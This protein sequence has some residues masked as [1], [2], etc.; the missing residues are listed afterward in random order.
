MPTLEP[1]NESQIFAAP[2]SLRPATLEAA[3][4]EI[5]SALET[6]L[7]DRELSFE[8][9]L[10]LAT[11]ENAGFRALVEVADSLR[12]ATVGEA[13]TYVVNRNIN[14]TNVCF[15]GCSFC[16]F[17]RGPGNSSDERSTANVGAWP[18]W[19]FPGGL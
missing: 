5:R 12:L 8:Q 11:A 4:L 7:E 17:S 2:P 3:P 19:R 16:G 18:G 15:V 9:G 14:F 10:Q 6:V 13:I 1:N